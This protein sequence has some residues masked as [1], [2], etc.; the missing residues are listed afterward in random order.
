MHLTPGAEQTTAPPTS[1]PSTAAS[2]HEDEQ[3]SFEKRLSDLNE[4]ENKQATYAQPLV[5]DDPYELLRTN[6]ETGR[7]GLSSQRL[8]SS[9]S[10]R[11]MSHGESVMVRLSAFS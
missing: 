4:E 1:R 5:W 3:L 7:I 9:A 10:T 2:S 11:C 8:E 6:Q